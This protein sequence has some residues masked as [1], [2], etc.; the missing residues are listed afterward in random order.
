MKRA[1]IVLAVLLVLPPTLG[2]AQVTLQSWTEVYGTVGGQKLGAEVRNISP[3]SNLPYKASI[4]SFG[5]TGVYM[6]RTQNDTAAQ[7][8]FFGNDML[9]GDLNNDGWKDVVVHR[10]D[11]TNTRVDTVLVYWGTSTGI[12]TL[13]PLLLTGENPGDAFQSVCI[14]DVNN[15]GKNDLI[16]SAADFPHPFGRGKIYIFLN[17]V[18]GG[19]P[20]G[21]ILG[22]TVDSGLGTACAIG[23]PNNDGFQDLIL[24]GWNQLGPIPQRYD[25]INIYWGIAID[26][27]NLTLGLQ[28]RGYNLHS[29]GLACFDANGDGIDDL[30]WTNRATA[31]GLDR[32]F[33]HYGGPAFDTLANLILQNPGVANF[34][35]A[36]ANAGD[37]NGDGYS[38]IGVAAYSANITDGYVFVFGGGPRIDA[39]FDAFAGMDLNSN[40][41]WSVSSVGDINSDGLADIIVGAPAYAFGEE[42]GYWGVFKGDSTIRVTDVRE[43]SGVPQGFR[44][45][46]SYPN[47]FNP[48]ATIEFDLKQ[49]AFVTLRVYD[50]LGR[51]VRT[52]VNQEQEAG[53]YSITF[54]ARGLA[55]GTYFYEIVV[56]GLDGTITRE[57][58]KMLLLSEREKQEQDEYEKYLLTRGRAGDEAAYKELARFQ[59][60]HSGGRLKRFLTSPD[61]KPDTILYVKDA[62]V[63]FYDKDISRL[64]GLLK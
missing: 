56:K 15:D 43:T 64:K 60:E 24:R 57:T 51:E 8:V 11:P 48:S 63:Y 1:K 21:T 22:D 54:D 49:H 31:G 38:D 7:G 41:G 26:T 59:R 37:M 12:D 29:R 2:I 55:A 23:D 9:T 10:G 6:L 34:G 27:L 17:P 5:N 53:D 58:K 35:N 18:R 14:G 4:Y 32:V 61:Q 20:D 25:Y 47:P 52:L 45:Y 40:F 50:L 44:L 16:I 46:Q 33:V 3:T 19:T 42:K 13:S 28:L 36:I 39:R 62:T 30:L